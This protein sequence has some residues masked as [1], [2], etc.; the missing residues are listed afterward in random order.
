MAYI[1]AERDTRISQD[2]VLNFLKARNKGIEAM[3]G[4]VENKRAYIRSGIPLRACTTLFELIEPINSFIDEYNSSDKSTQDLVE[5]LKNIE[6]LIITI[7]TFEN[8]REKHLDL[9]NALRISWIS[10]I[11]LKKII[12]IDEKNASFVCSQYFGYKIPF[13]LNA[14][15]KRMKDEML[16]DESNFISEL[17]VL[18]ELGLPNMLAAK[19]FLAGVRSRLSALELSEII[20]DESVSLSIKQLNT[21]LIKIKDRIKSKISENTYE[22]LN[23]IENRNEKVKLDFNTI[24][25]F[26]FKDNTHT[27]ETLNVRSFGAKLYLCTPDYELKIEATDNELNFIEA[28][29]KLDINF[30]Y[31]DEIEV[32]QVNIRNP[33]L[34]R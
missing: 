21:G 23:L 17:A 34:K 18:C 32:Y 29:D 20:N 22:W 12:E 8:V 9:I 19:I 27:E 31:N 14:I 33:K 3:L 24:S 2:D 25:N 15:A 13:L 11:P 26:T 10:G 7:P 30:I 16:E 1:Q 4:D 5:L 6:T 28:S